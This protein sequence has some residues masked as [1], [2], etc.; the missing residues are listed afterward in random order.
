[1]F[2]EKKY[3][4]MLEECCTGNRFPIPGKCRANGWHRGGIVPMMSLLDGGAAGDSCREV[5]FECGYVFK[6]RRWFVLKLSS[7]AI[8]VFKGH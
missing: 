5:C 7:D 8:N 3:L 1:M 6:N 2:F 4:P